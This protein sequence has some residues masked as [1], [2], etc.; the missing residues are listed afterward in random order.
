MPAIVIPRR[1]LVQPQ[2]YARVADGS[3][4][5]YLP[6]AGIN[7]L[8]DG[9]SLSNSGVARAIGNSG[10]AAD[11]DAAA[12]YLEYTQTT[13]PL[14]AFHLVA[15]VDLNA[16]STFSRLIQSGDSAGYEGFSIWFAPST[17]S[18][19]VGNP[20]SV[21]IGRNSSP[22]TLGERWSTAANSLVRPRSGVVLE[23]IWGA[24]ASDTT[25]PQVWINGVEQTVTKVQSSTSFNADFDTLSGAPLRIGNRQGTAD[26]ALLG[27][28]YLLHVEKQSRITPYINPWQL[29]GPSPRRLYFDASSSSGNITVSGKLAIAASDSIPTTSMLGSIIFSAKLVSAKS[30]AI[31]TFVSVAG[32][33]GT[34][35]INKIA[36]GISTAISGTVV[37]GSKLIQGIISSAKAVAISTTVFIYDPSAT[38]TIFQRMNFLRRFI[39]RR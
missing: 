33:S 37:L 36:A 38:P 21:V 25:A 9:R 26:R 8:L 18:G 20:N 13:D 11:I 23:V 28:L 35:V 22:S 12:D 3:W 32:G 1:Q 5:T 30:V 29:F 16:S 6:S 4:M 10:V 14:G 34:T 2:G 39:G 17:S 24:T 31:A 19:S 27:K 15:V 7:S